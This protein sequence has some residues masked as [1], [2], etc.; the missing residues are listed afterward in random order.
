MAVGMGVVFLGLTLLPRSF[1]A[2]EADFCKPDKES[3]VGEGQSGVRMKR[4]LSTRA[5]AEI[6]SSFSSSLDSG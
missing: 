1:E 3:K 5:K 6:G 2:K 4:T